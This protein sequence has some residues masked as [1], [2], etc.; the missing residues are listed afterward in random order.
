LI[1]S[2]FTVSSCMMQCHH[3]LLLGLRFTSKSS[4][5][6]LTANM[7]FTSTCPVGLRRV[8]KETGANTKALVL[9]LTVS[10]STFPFQYLAYDTQMIVGG[11][12]HE[13]SPEEYIFGALQLY[14]D[15]V[16]LFLI[17]LS[18]FGNKE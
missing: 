10:C 14:M 2:Q 9:P 5:R 18:L 1:C 17:I 13:M 7:L 12:K 15:V 16:Y 8:G 3:V 4:S 11:R 6:S